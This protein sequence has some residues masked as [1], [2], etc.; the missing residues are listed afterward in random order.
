MRYMK[1]NWFLKFN[2][3]SCFYLATLFQMDKQIS[4]FSY[5]LHW[6]ICMK[7][8]HEILFPLLGKRVKGWTDLKIGLASS[9]SLHGSRRHGE[10]QI[11]KAGF[12]GNR[13]EHG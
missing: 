10:A 1:N 12:K 6:E 8:S 9:P 13:V 4:T 5:I 2:W 3:V 7:E 11:L